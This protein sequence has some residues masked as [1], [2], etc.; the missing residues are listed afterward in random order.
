MPIN[1]KNLIDNTNIKVHIFKSKYFIDFIQLLHPQLTTNY[2]LNVTLQ[3]K[4]FPI[5][6]YFHNILLQKNL[7]SIRRCLPIG[8]AICGQKL[9]PYKSF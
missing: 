7:F 3:F 8:L 5:S 6:I 1:L 2:I 9:V 4:E